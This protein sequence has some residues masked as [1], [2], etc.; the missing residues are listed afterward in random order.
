MSLLLDIDMVETLLNGGTVPQ[1][2]RDHMQH[3]LDRAKELRG[4]QVLP[5]QVW[6]RDKRQ[7]LVVGVHEEQ[8]LYRP[9]GPDFVLG[10]QRS[11]W[12]G[13]WR[14]NYQPL[15]TSVEGYQV[16]EPAVAQRGLDIL[17]PDKGYHIHDKTEQRTLRQAVL[18]GSRPQ[19]QA[20]LQ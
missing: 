9:I 7:W 6:S 18:N 15:L 11:C 2:Q 1:S 13:P 8:I 5:W 14:K 17:P 20:I 16:C 3:V 10:M 12:V 4:H 19:L